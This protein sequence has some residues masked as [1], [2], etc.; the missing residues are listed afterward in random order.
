MFRNTIYLTVQTM[1]MSNCNTLKF[2][3]YVF[4]QLDLHQHLNV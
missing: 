2:K 4:K 1:T 3:R